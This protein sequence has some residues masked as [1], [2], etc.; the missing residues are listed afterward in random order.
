MYQ[1]STTRS[2]REANKPNFVH[3]SKWIDMVPDAEGNP[4]PVVH[5]KTRVLTADET[6][7]KLWKRKWYRRSIVGR[8]Q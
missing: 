1:R 7:V 8:L 4:K 3:Y 5:T 6:A 2:R